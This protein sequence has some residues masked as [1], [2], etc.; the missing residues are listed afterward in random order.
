MSE[1][2][3]KVRP[4]PGQ[5]DN[6]CDSVCTQD[7]PRLLEINP[8]LGLCDTCFMRNM[9]SVTGTVLK[10]YSCFRHFNTTKPV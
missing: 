3:V 8:R 10:G 2:P 9:L 4:T 7:T 1:V 5:V 6:I